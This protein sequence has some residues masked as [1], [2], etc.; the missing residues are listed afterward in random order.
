V[1]GKFIDIAGS[2]EERVIRVQM[3]VGKLGGHISMLS[4]QPVRKT[5][6]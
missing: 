6:S 2:I 5:R 1:A 3:E 4:L